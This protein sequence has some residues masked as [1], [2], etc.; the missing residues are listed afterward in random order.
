M[1]PPSNL[2]RLITSRVLVRC[3]RRM[4]MLQKLPRR[5]VNYALTVRDTVLKLLLFL[6][7]VASD[8]PRRAL[9]KWRVTGRIRS[10]CPW[11]SI[12]VRHVDT[13]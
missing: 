3:C 11:P 4:M 6:T 2:F 1:K 10:H 8:N 13:I 5:L 12:H 9:L 7:R